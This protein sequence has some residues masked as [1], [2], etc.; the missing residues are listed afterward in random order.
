MI[1]SLVTV[2]GASG[3]VGRHTVRALAKEGWRVRAVTRRPN[4]ANYLYPAGH[5]GQIQIVR[6]NVANDEDVARAVEGAEAVVNTTGMMFGGGEEGIDAINHEAAGRIAR[7]AFAAGANSLVHISAIGANTEAESCYARAKGWGEREVR[8][9]FPRST[10]LRPS[11]V[12]GPEDRFFNRFASLARFVPA[13]PLIGGGHT[14]FQPVYVRD[15]ATAVMRSLGDH[16]ARGRIF[17]LG[18][19]KTY[20]FRELMEF[21]LAETGRKRLLVPLPYFL[22]KVLAVGTSVGTAVPNLVRSMF[23]IKA[24]APLLTVDQ[25]RLLKDDNI[26]REGAFVLEDLFITPSTVEAIVP[27]YLWRYHPKGQFRDQAQQI[28]EHATSN[29]ATPA[30]QHR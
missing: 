24:K 4:L 27:G 26:V 10:I 7:A 16:T 28:A 19:P 1:E 8:E 5:V 6:G 13:L 22:A 18:G 17:E 3:F 29:T 23:D 25:V 2:F 15:V 12:F 30:A 21:I 9:A 11:L 14:K 20:S